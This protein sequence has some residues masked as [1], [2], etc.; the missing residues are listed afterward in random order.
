MVN[1]TNGAERNLAL[2]YAAPGRPRAAL[3]ALLA[4]DDRLGGIVRAAR[5]PMVGQMRLTW[6]FEALRALDAGPPPAE[7]VLAALAEHALPGGATGAALA[8]MVD[9]WERLLGTETLTLGA[10]EQAAAERGGR[11]FALGAT[12]LHDRAPPP[13][14]GQGWALADFGRHLSDGALA[15][16][17]REA[18]AGLL[19]AA[20]A[21]RWPTRLRSLG[22]IA[23]SARMNLRGGRP[24]GHPL[25]I[26]RL[27]LHRMTG[28]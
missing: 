10:M 7:P 9:G 15:G 14:A 8:E 28:R 2:S 26:G 20:F 11:L 1:E 13:E 23:L 5:E 16:A 18:A 12:V 25:R 19:D 24:A 21:G 27:A 22:A 3:G 6:W 17:A 4:L